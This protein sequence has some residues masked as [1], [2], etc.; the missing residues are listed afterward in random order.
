MPVNIPEIQA[1]PHKAIFKKH[2]LS[3]GQ[4]AR[5]I[6]RSYPYTSNVLSGLNK[7]GPVTRERLDELVRQ[8]EAGK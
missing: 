7:G 4:V 5:Y 2:R 1:L 8:L 6:D 3:I